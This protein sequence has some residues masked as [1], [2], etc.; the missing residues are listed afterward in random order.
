MNPTAISY[1]K[2]GRPFV[3]VGE[4]N[5]LPF[6]GLQYHPEKPLFIYD[7]KLK[8]DHSADSIFFNRFVADFIVNNCKFN[9]QKF[10]NYTT[11]IK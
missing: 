7:P 9:Y 11:E 6:F 2:N 10:E 5:E 1:D 3:A 8:I 4:G